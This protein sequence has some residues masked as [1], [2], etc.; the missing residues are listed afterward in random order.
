L[1]ETDI[2]TLKELIVWD[3]GMEHIT[4]KFGEY[5]EGEKPQTEEEKNK[6]INQ[7]MNYENNKM[8]CSKEE[9]F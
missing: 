3:R 8:K 9:L 4:F 7:V 6:I 5:K 1:N 2:K